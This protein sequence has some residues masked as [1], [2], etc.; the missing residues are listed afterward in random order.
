MSPD[1]AWLPVDDWTQLANRQV[2]IWDED[3][4]LD[5]GIVEVVTDDG[6][7]LWLKQEGV[8]H[9][10]AIEKVMNRNIKVIGSPPQFRYG[11]LENVPR[12]SGVNH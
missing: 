4:L 9:R 6:T 5:Q 8:A 12:T 1:V 10:R 7:V 11:P 3:K 2:E